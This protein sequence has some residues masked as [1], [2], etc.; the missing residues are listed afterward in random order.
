MAQ[1]NYSIKLEGKSQLHEPFIKLEGIVINIWSVNNGVS[2]EN[3][4]VIL[5]VTGKL[6]IYM[7]CKA[8]SGTGWKFCIN[9]NELNKDIYTSEGVTGEKLDSQQ[10]K[11]IPNFSERKTSV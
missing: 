3:K 1:K 10:G 11:R 2:W 7:S 6:D 9:D 5:D 8:M 4:N